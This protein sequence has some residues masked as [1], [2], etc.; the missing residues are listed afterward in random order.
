MTARASYCCTSSFDS[1]ADAMIRLR[2]F[3]R[4]EGAVPVGAATGQWLEM[5]RYH[6]PGPMFYASQRVRRC[7]PDP[8]PMPA[9]RFFRWLP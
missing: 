6:W 2:D 7:D 8:S 3:V 4:R 1:E 9:F 5:N